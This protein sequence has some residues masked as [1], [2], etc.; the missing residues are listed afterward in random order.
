MSSSS[1]LEWQL[2]HD[3]MSSQ[4]DSNLSLLE[5]VMNS[6]GLLAFLDSINQTDFG[7]LE[8]EEKTVID[9][10]EVRPECN[11]WANDG[12]LSTQISLGSIPFVKMEEAVD[13]FV[14]QITSNPFSRGLS[15]QSYLLDNLAS[16]MYD[17]ELPQPSSNAGSHNYLTRKRSFRQSQDSYLLSSTMKRPRRMDSFSTM[18]SAAAFVIK[19]DPAGPAPTVVPPVPFKRNGDSQLQDSLPMSQG[20]LDV[21]APIHVEPGIAGDVHPALVLQ[22]R[23]YKLPKASSMVQRLQQRNRLMLPLRLIRKLFASFEF[24]ESSLLSEICDPTS[25]RHKE[26]YAAL[27]SAQQMQKSRASSQR[28]SKKWMSAL[29]EVI[30]PHSIG[31]HKAERITRQA[32]LLL[33]ATSILTHHNGLDLPLPQHVYS[34]NLSMYHASME[35]FLHQ[36]HIFLSDDRKA[37]IRDALP[38]LFFFF[39]ELFTIMPLKGNLEVCLLLLSFLEGDGKHHQRGGTNADV[40]YKFYREFLQFVD[41]SVMPQLRK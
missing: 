39:L 19:P 23:F 11:E 34:S 38:R 16:F 6:Q 8:D 4:Q 26:V 7:T 33:L 29:H 14:P 12:L 28:S 10:N 41:Q 21:A 20:E 13:G 9:E 37:C 32:A 24:V 3:A 36:N 40:T 2:N 30:P 25:A 1:L 31:D 15:S 22:R 35:K 18:R 17:S 5:G 27:T